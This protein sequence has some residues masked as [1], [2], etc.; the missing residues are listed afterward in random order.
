MKSEDRYKFYKST[1][2][3][4]WSVA[5]IARNNRG[6]ESQGGKFILSTFC[7][8]AGEISKN[9]RGSGDIRN[10]L[11]RS[12]FNNFNKK[13]GKTSRSASKPTNT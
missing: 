3:V 13:V 5:L 11:R 8:D 10:S 9:A 7:F 4:Q 6:F 1:L 2:V 12:T